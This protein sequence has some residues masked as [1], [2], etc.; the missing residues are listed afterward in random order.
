MPLNPKCIICVVI[1]RRSG[2]VKNEPQDCRLKI[3]NS[4]DKLIDNDEL[5]Q[6]NRRIN[7][8]KIFW[9]ITNIGLVVCKH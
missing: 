3:S 6:D 7:V 9:K 8:R 5:I 1:L 2:R 4:E